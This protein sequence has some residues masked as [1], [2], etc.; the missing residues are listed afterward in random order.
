M[1]IVA[2]S[3]LLMGQSG[4]VSSVPHP[5]SEDARSGLGT[6]GIVSTS[7][8]TAGG[9]ST[10]AK[11]REGGAV[12]GGTEGAAAG[13][14]GGAALLAELGASTGISAVALAGAPVIAPALAILVGVSVLVGAGIGAINAIPKETAKKIEAMLN[15]AL[16]ELRLAET[17]Q[18]HIIRTTSSQT[19]RRFVIIEGQ[20]PGTPDEVADYRSQSEKGIDTVLEASVLSVRF[21][22]KGGK[23]PLLSFKMDLRARLIRTAD[24]TVQYEHT[25]EYRSS[26]RK[27]SQWTKD[28]AKP[29]LDELDRAYQS[30][31]EKVTEE[32]FLV[33]D[34]S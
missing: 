33:Y 26:K 4:C 13:A 8:V 28:K 24:G 29:F 17:L 3:S 14:L 32:I 31:A 27:F 21:D 9:L 12:K 25:L 18:D 23:D 7:F 11:S 30:L 10:Y 2:C 19:N 16:S 22:G 5:L 1:A 15:S 34:L 20:G 6:V